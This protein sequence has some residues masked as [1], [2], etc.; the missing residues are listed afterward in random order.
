MRCD[1]WQIFIWFQSHVS[2]KQ[3]LSC[4]FFS[5]EHLKVYNILSV[6]DNHF[7]FEGIPHSLC[8]TVLYL[9]KILRAHYQNQHMKDARW[10]N[11]STL[12]SDGKL[13][14]QCVEIGHSQNEIRYFFLSLSYCCFPISLF[15]WHT[16]NIHTVFWSVA[17]M[18]CIL[19]C[20]SVECG[21]WIWSGNATT[22]THSQNIVQ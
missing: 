10:K 19:E 17:W 22:A 7:W 6:N 13:F 5:V 11:K 20:L 8:R 3:A 18:Q 21:V 15:I 2:A 16:Y 1:K 4:A 14:K 9:S 12:D